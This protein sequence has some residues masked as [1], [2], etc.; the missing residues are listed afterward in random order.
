[1]P[2]TWTSIAAP[3]AENGEFR[4]SIAPSFHGGAGLM[5]ATPCAT[6]EEA[7]SFSRCID[8]FLECMVEDLRDC[9]EEEL[10]YEGSSWT[11]VYLGGGFYARLVPIHMDT[12][13][14]GYPHG[15]AIAGSFPDKTAA[16]ARAKTVDAE[17]VSILES[18][19]PTLAADDPLRN[20]IGQIIANAAS[21]NDGA[22]SSVPR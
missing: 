13:A 10:D 2:R 3:E 20:V 21:V 11:R 7:A 1:M 16:E 9:T 14:A 5:L 17:M 12:E 8:R 4:V 19:R 6:E 22:N 18:L 15:L